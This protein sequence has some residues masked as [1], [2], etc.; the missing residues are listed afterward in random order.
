MSWLNVILRSS[1][2][3]PSSLTRLAAV[4]VDQRRPWLR[5]GTV[6]GERRYQR[7]LVLGL[8]S[9]LVLSL[10]PVVGTHLLGVAE[11][12][13]SGSDHLGALCLIALHELLSPAHHLLHSL[14]AVGFSW[15]LVELAQKALRTRRVLAGLPTRQLAASE[16]AAQSNLA[17][18]QVSVV[19]GLPMPAFTAGRWLRPHVYVAEELLSGEHALTSDEVVAVLAHEAAHLHRRDPMRFLLLRVLARALFWVPALRAI[20]EDIADEAEI[21]A[22]DAASLVTGPITVASAL[23]KLGAWKPPRPSLSVVGF[24]RHDLLERRVRRLVGEEY[25]PQ[26]RLT[27]GSVF[28]ATLVLTVSMLSGV[29]DVHDLPNAPGHPT[30]HRHCE[31][32]GMFAAGHLLCR[33]GVSGA[34]LPEGVAD[35]PHARG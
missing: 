8:G 17:P 18:G 26:S 34:V 19:V 16:L 28:V 25:R 35:C 4:V 2:I 24:L 9:I 31:H 23:V 30:S 5:A 22:D 6:A 21:V 7:M 10:A 15:A 14:V 29:V 32:D 13:L 1:T 3:W 33:W 20:A 27:G 11:R 12:P